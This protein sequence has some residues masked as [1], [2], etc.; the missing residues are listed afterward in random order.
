[1]TL[2]GIQNKTSTIDAAG[3]PTGSGYLWKQDGIPISTTPSVVTIFKASATYTVECIGIKTC[4]GKAAELKV[5]IYPKITNVEVVTACSGSSSKITT[6]KV[7][8]ANSGLDNI[9][10]TAIITNPK[11]GIVFANITLGTPTIS[12]SVYTYTIN[13]SQALANGIYT[14]SLPPIT[15]SCPVEYTFTVSNTCCPDIKLTTKNIAC[16]N[17][18][19]AVTFEY[20][21]GLGQKPITD[22]TLQY[23][24]NGIGMSLPNPTSSVGTF[25]VTLP[26]QT[27]PHTVTL[28]VQIGTLVCEKTINVN[29]N[30]E[31]VQPTFVVNCDDVLTLNA[32]TS[33]T[34]YN[35]VGPQNAAF[36]SPTAITSNALIG[37]TGDVYTVSG[38]GS[39]GKCFNGNVTINVNPDSKI[40]ITTAERFCIDALEEQINS[41]TV[42][43][44]NTAPS[45]IGYTIDNN[46]QT[47]IIAQLLS[48]NGNVG[49]YKINKREVWNGSHTI[50]F[51]YVIKNGLLCAK[52]KDFTFE[53]KCECPN[54]FVTPAPKCI[55]GTNTADLFLDIVL[56]KFNTPT[57]ANINAQSFAQEFE[58]IET[59]NLP[60]GAWLPLQKTNILG[61]YKIPNIQQSLDPYK[62]SVRMKAYPSCVQ[63]LVRAYVNSCLCPAL[64]YTQEVD[65][66]K[67]VL[68]ITFNEQVRIGKD[69]STR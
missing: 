25:T 37:K 57:I 27:T 50:K 61:R 9:K 64:A 60:N 10:L 17:S 47:P 32:N 33:A 5:I 62:I 59:K 53:T 36:T 44:D 1:L 66:D 68:R 46:T 40:V 42:T 54:I 38:T 8:T 29:I 23:L 55:S 49:T 51:Y 21:L 4:P 67:N 31:I 24:R 45:S 65:C 7:T 30:S 63:P 69:Y 22:V 18:G 13:S 6:I 16:K 28:R 34:L 52:N 19:A 48:S 26:N 2:C 41:L 58:Y 39:N 43:F 3:C 20:D 15:N 11:S 56:L 35:W 14:I 12:G